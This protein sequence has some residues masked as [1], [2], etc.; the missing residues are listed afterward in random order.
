LAVDGILASL[1]L[2]QA[3]HVTAIFDPHFFDFDPSSTACWDAS[4]I[5]KDLRGRRNLLAL[6]FGLDDC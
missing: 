4:L 2:V 5:L 3:D 6:H 1:F